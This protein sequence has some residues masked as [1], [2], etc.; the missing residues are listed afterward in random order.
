MKNLQ[1]KP[2]AT[3]KIN[4][5]GDENGVSI[6]TNLPYSPRKMTWKGKSCVTSSQIATEKEKRI[7]KLKTKRVKH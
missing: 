2:T 1:Q 6:P 3:R 7:S 4:F 5:R